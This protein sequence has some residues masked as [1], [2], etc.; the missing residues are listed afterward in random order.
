HGS[1]RVN[2]H[3][4]MQ[5]LREKLACVPRADRGKRREG[6][7]DRHRGARP[8]G[9]G[10]E[11][12]GM[13]DD[14]LWDGS[15]EPDPEIQKMENALGKLRYNRPAPEFP[16]LA[17]TDAPSPRRHFWQA[18]SWPQFAVA[19]ATVLLIAAASLA[20]LESRTPPFDPAT[21]WDVTRV[22]GSPQVGSH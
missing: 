11:G 4:G 21:A 3:R 7:F 1:V 12:L 6:R 17:R 2:L 8:A 19:G 15:G 22:E 20:W 14:Y 13:R 9:M 5:K 18:F 16:N 10:Y